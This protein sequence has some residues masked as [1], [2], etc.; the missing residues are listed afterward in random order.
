MIVILDFLF[1]SHSLVQAGWED[2][3]LASASRPAAPAEAAPAH[4]NP[5]GQPPPL[6]AESS[7]TEPS[8]DDLWTELELPL[9]PGH[10][11]WL[12]LRQLE[13]H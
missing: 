4:P 5:S 10:G 8:Q 1:F 9:M 7:Q 13:D 12:A 3:N 11:R 6:H 2:Q